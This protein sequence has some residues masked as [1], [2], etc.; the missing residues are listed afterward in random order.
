[1]AKETGSLA[2]KM[3]ELELELGM[4]RERVCSLQQELDSR[5]VPP[6][7]FFTDTLK[8]LMRE[9]GLVALVNNPNL[10]ESL[11]DSAL[12]ISTRIDAKLKRN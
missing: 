4:L 6:N 12:S 8:L 2:D 3:E 10:L 7:A 1:M 5:V 9:Q 11:V